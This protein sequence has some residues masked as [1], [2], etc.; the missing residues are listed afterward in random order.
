MISAPENIHR[1][2]TSIGQ[3]SQQICVVL[4]DALLTFSQRFDPT[5]GVQ[6]RRVVS[7]AKGIPDLG[8]AVA[9]EFFRERHRNL[10]GPSNR[11]ASALGQQIGNANFE[12]VR[13]RLLNV[14]DRDEPGLQREEVPQRFLREIE[15][16]GLS[17]ESGIRDHPP[18][19]TLELANIRAN[20]LGDE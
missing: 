18:Q 11:A 10:T 1:I 20:S 6:H 16:D 14:F 4:G 12:I 3:S 2:P 15:R 8:K 17:R 13:H 7:S 9:R 5:T 19:G